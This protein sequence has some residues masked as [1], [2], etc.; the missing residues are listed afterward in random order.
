VDLIF[1]NLTAFAGLATATDNILNSA[2]VVLGLGLVIFF[3]ELGH[4]VVAKWCNVHVERFSIGIGP[5]LWSRQKGETEYALSALPFGGYVKMLGQDDMDPNQMTSEEI[6]ENPRAYSAK[7][8]PQRMAIISAGVT[9]NVL[10]GFLFF[11]IS[12]HSGVWKRSPVVGGV[13][14]GLPAWTANLHSS[15]R[16]QRINGEDMRSFEDIQRAIVLSIGDIRIEGVHEGGD[17]FDVTIVPQIG[18][19][20]RSVGITPSVEPQFHPRL[21]DATTIAIPGFPSE[22]ASEPFAAGDRIVAIQDQPV[23]TFGDVRTLSAR[24][25]PEPLVYTVKRAVGQPDSETT[26][27]TE[28]HQITVPASKV[29][30]IGLW[31]TMG[32]IRAIRD[33]SIAE[34]AGL[35]IDD[36][37][38]EVDGMD[39]GHEFNPVE[40]PK[41]FG[42]RA[43]QEVVLKV[44]RSTP[45]APQV[46]EIRIVPSDI[47]G[48]TASLYF[49]TSPLPVPSIGAA[50]QVLPRIAHIVPGSE[51]EKSGRFELKQKVTQVELIPVDEG[52]TAEGTTPSKT[53][54]SLESLEKGTP[55]TVEDINWAYAFQAMQLAPGYH[56]R[57]HFESGDDRPSVLLKSTEEMDDWYRWVRGLNAAAWLP[58][59]E[60][61]KG[62]SIGDSLTLGFRET[63]N[64]GVNIYLTLRSLIRGDL[65]VSNLSGPLGIARVAFLV[66][67]KGFVD[68]L[69]FLG[70]LSINL[71]ILNFLPIPVLDG[72]H[73]VFLIWEGVTR[74]KPSPRVIGWAHGMG[75]LFIISLFVFVMYLDIFVNKFGF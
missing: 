31:M 18:E 67:D 73:M 26:Q 19:T 57:I 3:H 38:I 58:S 54:I 74:R 15:D 42:E 6:A 45:A 35:Q 12:F 66:A 33:G 44:E 53:S 17:A 21:I 69:M 20:G 62:E 47:P 30:S 5:I 55:G 52:E 29:R 63:K 60:L 34:K 24:F 43:G 41:Y 16:I 39:I 25:A 68:L 40:L 32:P 1:N 4:F 75:I 37:I 59:E 22:N 72:G 7:S 70:F 27:P 46:E 9:M 48:W 14:P 36:R 23:T 13:M 65:A 64:T 56:V 71:A 8:V 28:K 2:Q 49:P 61:Q 11:A 50:Y 51:A 10:T